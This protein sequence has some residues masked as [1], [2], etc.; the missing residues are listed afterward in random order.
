MF[1]GIYKPMR[2]TLPMPPRIG[3]EIRF[4]T[5]PPIPDH[6]TFKVVDITLFTGDLLISEKVD[7]QE[8]VVMPRVVIQLR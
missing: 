7:G 1:G 8:E 4:L 2:V 5:T 6:K 3:Y